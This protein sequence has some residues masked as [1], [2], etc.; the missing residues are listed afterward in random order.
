MNAWKWA[1]VFVL[2]LAAACGKPKEGDVCQGGDPQCADDHTLLECEDDGHYRAIGC[3]GPDGC[4][5]DNHAAEPLLVCDLTG[6]QTGDECESSY[7]GFVLCDETHTHAL[8]C[9]G[10]IW[11]AEP[12]PNGTCVDGVPDIDGPDSTGD[13]E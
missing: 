5:F 2:V 1:V 6:T 9:G 7:Q 12:C 8:I 10:D 3:P 11:R 13:C 4:V